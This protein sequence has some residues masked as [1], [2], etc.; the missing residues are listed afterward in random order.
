MGRIDGCR[1]VGGCSLPRTCW[2]SRGTPG[3]SR[4]NPDR[5]DSQ[6][7][8]IQ[9]NQRRMA[10][11]DKAIPIILLHEGGLVAVS[12]Q[13]AATCSDIFSE[14]VVVFS[15]HIPIPRTRSLARLCRQ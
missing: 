8:L 11:F 2:P 5:K 6:L 12:F 10:D 15:F 4:R 14:S 3:T 9:E 13:I 7:H 1:P